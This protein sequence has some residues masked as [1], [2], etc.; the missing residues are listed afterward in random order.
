M[1]SCSLNDSGRHL[2]PRVVGG[3]GPADLLGKPVG[4]VI[5]HGSGLG[6]GQHRLDADAD[7]VAAAIVLADR[8]DGLVD[9]GRV[10]KGAKLLEGRGEFADIGD[11]G[12]GNLAIKGLGHVDLVEDGAARGGGNNQQP[13]ALGR[14]CLEQRHQ[15]LDHDVGHA[16]TDGVPLD[17]TLN[18]VQDQQTKRRLVGVGKHLVQVVLL[19]RLVEVA[20]EVLGGD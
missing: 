16:R 1:C 20:D 7:L 11:G 3:N 15:S 19:A 4:R 18:V 14:R 9:V 13:V 5:H 2:D 17:K 6:H 10:G 12:D 8:V